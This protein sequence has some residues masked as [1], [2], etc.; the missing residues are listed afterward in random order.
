MTYNILDCYE[1]QEGDLFSLE[2]EK[3]NR[4]VIKRNGTIAYDT[5]TQEDAEEY[6][7]RLR[8]YYP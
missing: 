4:L 6:M 5:I 1:T 8:Q 7:Q 2:R 3:D